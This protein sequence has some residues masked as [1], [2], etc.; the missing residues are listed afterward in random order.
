MKSWQAKE[1]HIY[2]G[3]I[4]EN[5]ELVHIVIINDWIIIA[6]MRVFPNAIVLTT[7]SHFD[8][9]KFIVMHI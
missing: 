2:G 5:I 9:R 4:D 8:V 1:V 7:K 6:L 3:S